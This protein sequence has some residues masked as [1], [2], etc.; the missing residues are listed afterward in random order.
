MRLFDLA[1]FAAERLRSAAEGEP[2]TKRIHTAE[3]TRHLRGSIP[4]GLQFAS[5]CGAHYEPVVRDD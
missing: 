3:R 2:T 5:T 4:I 1:E